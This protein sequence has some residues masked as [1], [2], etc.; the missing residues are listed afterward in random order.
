MPDTRRLLTALL[1]LSTLAAGCVA[2]PTDA[3]A[4]GDATLAPAEAAAAPASLTVAAC[5]E[6]QAEF[7]T[8]ADDFAGGLPAGF[9]LVRDTAGVASV[10]VVARTCD[11]AEEAAALFA[12]VLVTP[13][14]EWA[15][16][17]GAHGV[18]LSAWTDGGALG[19]SLGAWGVA[20]QQRAIAATAT[21]A[22]PVWQARIEVEPDFVLTLHAAGDAV[23]AHYGDLRL[24]ALDDEGKVGAAFD[25][26]RVG[27]DAAVQGAAS[28]SFIVALTGYD[29]PDHRLGVGRLV[30][31][32]AA[33]AVVT[34]R[35]ASSTS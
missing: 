23:A 31:D 10:G 5:R 26:A 21:A 11:A 16:A 30:N 4:P 17:A 28:A 22:G 18:L 8:P 24:F 33:A 9:T 15:A 34:Y 14:A 29:L 27:G 20:S 6:V 25:T 13:P 12:F 7:P 35:A 32:G 19:D 2:T 3:P 1:L